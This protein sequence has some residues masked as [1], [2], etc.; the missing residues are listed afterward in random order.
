[1]VHCGDQRRTYGCFFFPSCGFRGLNSGHHVWQ[2]VPFYLLSSLAQHSDSQSDCTGTSY[3]PFPGYAE[4][5]LSTDCLVTA[6]A[7]FPAPPQVRRLCSLSLG[8]RL[9]ATHSPQRPDLGL[10]LQVRSL[11]AYRLLIAIL[12]VGWGQHQAEEELSPLAFGASY[13]CFLLSL[14]PHTQFSLCWSPEPR[15][16]FSGCVLSAGNWNV[17]ACKRKHQNV[18]GVFQENNMEQIAKTLLY[19]SFSFPFAVYMCDQHPGA[20]EIQLWLFLPQLFFLTAK[21]IQFSINNTEQ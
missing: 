11:G 4:G 6:I 17:C 1:M 7:G 14:S 3:Q 10:G 19:G 18:W 13:P 16:C 2:Q 15:A 5:G 20:F 8:T 9:S 21:G 12:I